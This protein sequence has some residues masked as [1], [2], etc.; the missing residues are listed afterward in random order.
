MP[1]QFRFLRITGG[2]DGDRER[3]RI[4]SS[5]LAAFLEFSHNAP[6]ILNRHIGRA[7]AVAVV[8]NPLQALWLDTTHDDRRMG[9]LDRFGIGPE[10]IEIH[11]LPIKSG[12]VFS[13][14]GF[15]REDSLAQHFSPPVE[16]RTMV[17]HPFR[18][19]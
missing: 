9:F 12:L 8:D 6:K 4:T 1:V 14:N 16:T 3:A 17:F 11:K 15:Y 2:K 5:P 7:P 18:I 13:P 19:P 10:S